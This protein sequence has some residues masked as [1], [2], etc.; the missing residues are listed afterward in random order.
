MSFCWSPEVLQAARHLYLEQGLSASE[1]ARRI[2]TTRSALIAKAHRM[3]WAA[4]RDPGLAAANQVRGGRALA[5][6][7]R[8]RP[9]P[10]EIHLPT[11]TAAPVRATPRPWMERRPGQ[12]AYPVS[13]DGEAVMSCCAASGAQ[14][15]CAAHRRAM[16][17]RRTPAQQAALERVAEWVD[18]LEQP[19]AAGEA[20]G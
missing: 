7:L 14:S 5:R 9:A 19:R 17:L 8:P 3:G 12:C 1:S 20:A 15:Y 4:E 6:A 16:Y 11:P 2:G 18:Q 13:G 10:R